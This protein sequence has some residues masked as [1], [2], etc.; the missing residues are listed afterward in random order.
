MTGRLGLAQSDPLGVVGFQEV[1]TV[2]DHLVS[3]LELPLASH[4]NA[5][6]P[7]V[8]RLRRRRIARW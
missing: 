1:E 7:I 8:S 4:G 2:G 5:L 3:A 6:L